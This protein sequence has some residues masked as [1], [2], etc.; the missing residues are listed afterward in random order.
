[1]IKEVMVDRLD[2]ENWTVSH[3][4]IMKFSEKNTDESIQF[5]LLKK[6]S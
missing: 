4:I 2:G 6:S 3:Y 1:M 5:W